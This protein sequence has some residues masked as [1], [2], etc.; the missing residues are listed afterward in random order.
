MEVCIAL[1]IDAI[2][3]ALFCAQ[4]SGRAKRTPGLLDVVPRVGWWA[5]GK[6]IFVGWVI[7]PMIMLMTPLSTS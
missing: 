4:K 5:R 1:R 2:V 7:A 3:M 6:A